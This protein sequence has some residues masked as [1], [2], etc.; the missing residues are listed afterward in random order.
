MDVY[1]KRGYTHYDSKKQTKEGGGHFM[2][3]KNSS[4]SY[5]KKR[6]GPCIVLSLRTKLI[7][8][9]VAMITVPILLT[10]LSFTGIRFYMMHT[11]GSPTEAILVQQKISQT[12]F[13][14]M[15]ISIVLILCLSVMVL[16][17]LLQKWFVVPLDQMNEAMRNIAA[18]NF[19]YQM[20][21]AYTGEMGTLFDNY[22][23]MRMKLKESTE[24]SIESERKN[25]EMISNITHDLK[26]PITSIQG[27]VEGIMDGVADTPEKMDK[28]IR[29]IYNK[30][31]ELNRLI[32]ELGIYAKLD[33]NRIPYHFLRMNVHD[34]FQDCVEE[35]G[36]D[37]ESKNI[38]LD[39]SN[40]VDADTQIIADPEQLRRVISNII[41][42]S[43]KY[44]E[45]DDGQIDIRILDEIDSI[46]V[47]IEDNGKG[48]NQ[49]DLGKIFERFYRTDSS[50]NSGTG[51]SG[52][53]LSIVKKIIE[54][55]GGYIWATSKEG[56]G[57]CMHFVIRKILS[58]S[59]SE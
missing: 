47:E 49:K 56:E 9:C 48:I 24:E 30:A 35:V 14:D 40:L 39:F 26:T 3:E 31:N 33:S 4:R 44:L 50:R 23:Q 57:T 53:G 11:V 52:I 27:Y 13:F 36:L 45:R 1:L 38:K 16:K 17:I 43:V 7:I 42:N 41:G 46:R 15:F 21:V 12:F 51:G 54:D 25:Q 19:D 22:E 29:T 6:G 20:D 10:G 32:N 58:A 2:S 37:L 34:F 55:H 59:G 8:A 18:G 5:G 28:Y